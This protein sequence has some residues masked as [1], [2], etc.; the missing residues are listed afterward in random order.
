MESL[1]A[2]SALILKNQQVKLIRS[3]CIKSIGKT[4]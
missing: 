3:V 1:F 4:G 2:K